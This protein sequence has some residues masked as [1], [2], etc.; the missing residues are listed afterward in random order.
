MPWYI[1]TVKLLERGRAPH[2]PKNKITDTCV[3]SD[4]CTDQTGAHHSVLLD[5][6]DLAVMRASALHITRVELI[7]DRVIDV[8]RKSVGW[9]RVR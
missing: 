5:G 9:R 2:D 7:P 1:V 3:F 6:D 8:I 4:E